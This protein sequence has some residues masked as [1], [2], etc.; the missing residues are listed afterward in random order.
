MHPS[1]YGPYD[2]ERA[3]DGVGVALGEANV[4]PMPR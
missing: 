1:G 4:G 2:L 3:S